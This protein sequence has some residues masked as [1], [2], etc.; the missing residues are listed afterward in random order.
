[1]I[2]IEYKDPLAL[3]DWKKRIS[4][5]S[6][7]L[8]KAVKNKWVGQSYKDY[9]K[10]DLLSYY[11]SL[12]PFEKSIIDTA[13]NKKNS[14]TDWK[15]HTGPTKL[16]VP[17][18]LLDEKSYNF[19]EF[20]NKDDQKNLSRLFNVAPNDL[21]SLIDEL[22]KESG[23]VLKNDRTLKPE[24]RSRLF[25]VLEQIFVN[26]GYKSL[27]NKYEFLDATGVKVCPYCNHVPIDI[28]E[29]NGKQY[30]TGELD[31]FYCKELYPHLAL[32]LSNLVLSCG[33]C[34]GVGSGKGS[35]DMLDEKAVNPHVLE[36]SHGIDFDID[37]IGGGSVVDD[38]KWVDAIKIKLL[39]RIKELSNNN[40]VFGLE[41]IYNQDDLKRKAKIA[42]D[43][44][45]LY[46]NDP[47]KEYVERIL[48]S[49]GEVMREVDNE[50]VF[51]KK[52]QISRWESDYSLLPDSCF[53]MSIFKHTVETA[54]K[55]AIKVK[56]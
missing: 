55:G 12:S 22:D 26:D 20:L 14:T 33:G 34:N 6:E 5:V 40:T 4:N 10:K 56:L 45:K 41:S 39:Y 43:E 13:V 37:F 7:Y 25:K 44:G 28:R 29:N 36:H 9:T 50:Q 1:M 24:N 27:K 23:D 47:Y 48:S 18:V 2:R 3:V 51:Y 8:A 35:D 53:M 32:T 21:I 17:S 16:S 15:K 30:I 54:S 49:T 46:A 52:M 19:L 38:N 42:H 11:K 31:H